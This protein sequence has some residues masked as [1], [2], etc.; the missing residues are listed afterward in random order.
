[1][2]QSEVHRCSFIVAAPSIVSSSLTLS[3]TA[4]LECHHG[5]LGPTDADDE[6]LSIFP[7]VGS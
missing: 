3:F 6:V 7:D 4:F 1:M 5:F 2:H